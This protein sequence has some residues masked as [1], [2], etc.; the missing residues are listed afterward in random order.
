R[1]PTTRS[2]MPLARSCVTSRSSAVMNRRMSTETSSAGRRQFSELNANRVR[3]SMP[4]R[5]QASTV[6]RTAS[7]PLAW[8]AT[9]GRRRWVAQRPLPSMTI[10]TWRGTREAAGLIGIGS[11]NALFCSGQAVSDRHDFLFLVRQQLVDLRDELVGEL[12]DR[13]LGPT[14]VV[15]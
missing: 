1:S 13:I 15:L 11:E 12:L 4:S 3:N 6:V 7:T 10:A 8:P 9:R 2:R 5:A 14:L